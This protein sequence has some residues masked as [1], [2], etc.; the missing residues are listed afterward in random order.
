M[1]KSCTQKY[2]ISNPFSLM[3]TKQEHNV[4]FITANMLEL[5]KWAGHHFDERYVTTNPEAIESIHKQARL[6]VLGIV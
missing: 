1:L 3:V 5:W 2:A 4:I 6:G